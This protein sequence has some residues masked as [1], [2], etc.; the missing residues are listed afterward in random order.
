MQWGVIPQAFYDLIARIVP[1]GGVLFVGYWVLAKPGASIGVFG[2]A[3]TA[4]VGWIGRSGLPQLFAV[5]VLSYLT[6]RLLK[7]HAEQRM[8]QSLCTGLVLI[9]VVGIVLRG[10]DRHLLYPVLLVA[11]FLCWGGA[12]RSENYYRIGT[13]RAWLFHNFPLGAA[14]EERGGEHPPK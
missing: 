4:Q 7:V 14:R 10:G 3:G 8:L 12:K 9:V 13:Q 6:G 1:G 2:Q 11:G 5:F